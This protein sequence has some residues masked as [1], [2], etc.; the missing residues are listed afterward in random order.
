MDEAHADLLKVDLKTGEIEIEK[1]VEFSRYDY[2]FHTSNVGAYMS[3]RLER[4]QNK[5]NAPQQAPEPAP[6]M[7]GR[8]D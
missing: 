7:G 8:G 6:E 5:A 4:A 1:D 3:A 2:Q